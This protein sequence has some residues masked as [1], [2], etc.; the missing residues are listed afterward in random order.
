MPS[1]SFSREDSYVISVIGED[2]V[3]LVSEVTQ[4]LFKKGFNSE[5][6]NHG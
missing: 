2:R 6:S 4:F 3:G 5:G 1:Y